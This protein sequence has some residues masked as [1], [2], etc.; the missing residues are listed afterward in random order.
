MRRFGVDAPVSPFGSGIVDGWCSSLG[1][2]YVQVPLQPS[3]R[4]AM[5]EH[6]RLLI[7]DSVVPAG[8]SPHHA[9]IID[10]VMLS[11]VDGRE[12]EEGEWRQLLEAC[13]FQPVEIRDGLIQ[14]FPA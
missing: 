6:A 8:N 2:A 13:A 7:I 11:L 5:P 14:A 1:G 9:K 4:A 12:R 10:L 3:V